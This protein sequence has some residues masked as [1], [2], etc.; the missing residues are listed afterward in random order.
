[1]R[2][3]DVTATAMKDDRSDEKDKRDDDSINDDDNDSHKQADGNDGG[4]ET[5]SMI[6]KRED[7]GTEISSNKHIDRSTTTMIINYK[8]VLQRSRPYPY[9][10][11]AGVLKER[12]TIDIE[13]EVIGN[14][15]RVSSANG[16]IMNNNGAG[17]V[18]NDHDHDDNDHDDVLN[19]SSKQH[20]VLN[21]SKKRKVSSRG[22]VNVVP[23][24]R[25]KYL[26][27]KSSADRGGIHDGHGHDC[28][29]DNYT[30]T[31]IYVDGGND[32]LL[33]DVL[34]SGSM[35]TSNHDHSITTHSLNSGKAHIVNSK[36]KDSSRSKVKSSMYGGIIAT[37]LNRAIPLSIHAI[38]RR[39][40]KSK[41]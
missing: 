23:K 27:S 31:S 19:P 3:T 11:A 20:Q 8:E 38:D 24:S 13:V 34:P 29:D 25:K 4:N 39:M 32:V 41:G 16:H 5:E 9:N 22:M 12:A 6:N 37:G 15:A 36:S 18:S 35:A 28:S 30:E 10:S 1:L 21:R 40:A 26:E 7:T 17:D 14:H 2:T 33:G